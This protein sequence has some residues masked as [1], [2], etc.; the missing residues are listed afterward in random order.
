MP[1]LNHTPTHA[2]LRCVS[3]TDNSHWTKVTVLPDSFR[4][5]GVTFARGD[6]VIVTSRVTGEE[7]HGEI[8]V[9]KP[10]IVSVLYM[11]CLIIRW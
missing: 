3:A 10:K 6:P 11:Q 8:T 5:R 2:Q 4:V 1:T 7:F 9:V